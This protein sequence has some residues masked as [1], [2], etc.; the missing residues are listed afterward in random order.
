MV[1]RPNPR[2]R[3]VLAD[4]EQAVRGFGFVPGAPPRHERARHRRVREVD[5]DCIVDD[6]TDAA[7]GHRP[8]IGAGVLVEPGICVPIRSG[9]GRD[10]RNNDAA[11]LDEMSVAA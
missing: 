6:R 8:A 1:G 11:L 9:C 7:R 4:P 2:R 10:V 3:L 5:G